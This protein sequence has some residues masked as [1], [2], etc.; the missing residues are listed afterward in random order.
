MRNFSIAFLMFCCSFA[1]NAQ[2]T[3]KVVFHPDYYLTYTA[4]VNYYLAEGFTDYSI[5]KALGIITR[6][7]AGYNIDP[8]WGVRGALGFSSHTW[9]DKNNSYLP[10]ALSAENLTAD[11][12]V[13]LT[14]ALYG[15]NRLRSLSLSAFAG[16]GLGYRNQGVYSAMITPIIRGGAQ[17]DLIL[18]SELTLNLMGELNI[19]S[20]DYNNYTGTKVPFDV[21]PAITVGLS[22]RI[23]TERTVLQTVRVDYREK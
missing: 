14:N 9:P 16:A 4:G 17:F 12:T 22:Y 8:V 20:S 15:Y 5:L 11:A 19:V 23:P 2:F 7:S 1:A 6:F 21:Y 3:K 10:K 18:S 13:N